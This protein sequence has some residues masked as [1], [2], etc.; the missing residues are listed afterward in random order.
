M[1]A[2]FLLSDIYLSGKLGQ[3][4]NKEGLELMG[5][6]A[7]S[8]HIRARAMMGVQYINGQVVEKDVEKGV[9]YLR[10]AA[11]ADNLSAIHMMGF[12]HFHG[13]GVEK[14]L[15]KAAQFFN[16]AARGGD[17]TALQRLEGMVETGNPM[18]I[19][20]YGLLMKDGSGG[21]QQN[22]ERAAELVLEG[23]NQNIALAQFQI[24]HAYGVGQGF[25]QDY[26]KAHMYANLAAAQGY[27]GAEKRRDTWSQV[28]TAEQ[29]AEAQ[30]MARAWT[31]N[32]ENTP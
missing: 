29:I 13:E 24:S 3:A 8:G 32:F 30:E 11:N 7:E 10:S 14:D 9:E 21:V 1:D 12:L 23:A 25:E 20:L 28:M 16:A 17:I 4:N 15:D 18:A 5:R 27:E 22:A 2:Q 26:L 6:A 19:T 31:E